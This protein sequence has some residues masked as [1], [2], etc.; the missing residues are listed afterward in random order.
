[1]LMIKNSQ[2]VYFQNLLILVYGRFCKWIDDDL[3]DN[4]FRLLSLKAELTEGQRNDVNFA[5]PVLEHINIGK[6]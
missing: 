1:M 3:L 2:R 5:I 4:I 6:Q